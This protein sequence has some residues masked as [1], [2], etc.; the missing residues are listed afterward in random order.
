MRTLLTTIILTMLAQPVW[1][2]T[3][4]YCETLA[5]SQITN[6]DKVQNLRPYRFKMAVT[7]DS[8]EF[9][10]DD[11]IPDLEFNVVRSF[12]EGSFLGGAVW[13]DVPVASGDFAPPRLT[14]TANMHDTP[15]SFT[16]HCEDF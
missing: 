14:V 4:Y 5:F 16:A 9:S 12:G 10:G 15:F 3:V 11:F 13:A 1:A 8:V 6:D 2:K 7:S